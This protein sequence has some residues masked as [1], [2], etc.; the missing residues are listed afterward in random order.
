MICSAC[1]LDKRNIKAKN[2]PRHNCGRFGKGWVEPEVEFKNGFKYYKVYINQVVYET[3][4]GATKFYFTARKWVNGY[5]VKTESFVWLRNED[6][7]PAVMNSGLVA[8]EKYIWI[9]EEAYKKLA[10]V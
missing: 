3:A 5:K 6:F 1:E 8:K 2:P 10:F 9:K 4:S 7:E